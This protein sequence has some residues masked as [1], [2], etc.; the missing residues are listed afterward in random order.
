MPAWLPDCGAGKITTKNDFKSLCCFIDWVK[1]SRS[2][3]HKIGHFRD[4]LPRQSLGLVLTNVNLTQQKQT[5][6]RNKIYYNKP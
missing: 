4:V 1:V 5:C 3:Q 2:I 6:I